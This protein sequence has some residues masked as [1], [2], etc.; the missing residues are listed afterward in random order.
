MT[1]TE[2]LNLIEHYGWDIRKIDDNWYVEG[3]FGRVY[4]VSIREAINAALSAQA[5]WALS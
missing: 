4:K 3:Q 2:R 1:D 5:K